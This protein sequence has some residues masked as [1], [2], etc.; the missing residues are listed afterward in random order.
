VAPEPCPESADAATSIAD[1]RARVEVLEN[2]WRRAVAD[3][4]NLRK[5]FARD[6]E[7]VRAEERAAA[8]RH[9]LAVVD[10]LDRAIEY[11]EAD[12]QA[13]IE[14]V[15]AIRDQAVQMLADLG[16]PRRDDIGQSFDPARH[17]AVG[18]RPGSG[19]PPGTVVQVV[20]PAYGAGERQLRP[21]QVV[22]AKD[23]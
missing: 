7:R 20:R 23:S 14:G 13:I 1:L 11:A 3:A 10:N 9:W 22:V 8:A 12:P 17:D 21:A 16:F 2:E 19:A 18:S 4:E 15:R 6:I 5:R